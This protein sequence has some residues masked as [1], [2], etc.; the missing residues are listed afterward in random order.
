MTINA[1]SRPE[2]S[3]E[4]LDTTSGGYDAIATAAAGLISEYFGPK[5]RGTGM[6]VVNN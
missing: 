4:T 2:L 1:G 5:G 6:R 3:P